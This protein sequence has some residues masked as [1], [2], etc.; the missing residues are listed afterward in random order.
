MSSRRESGTEQLRLRSLFGFG[1]V[2]LTFIQRRPDQW[3]CAPGP[4]PQYSSLRQ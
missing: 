4:P 1:L 3:A 2:L